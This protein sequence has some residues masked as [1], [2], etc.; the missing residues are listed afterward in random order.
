MVQDHT[1][2]EGHRGVEAR[3]AGEKFVAKRE[4]RMNGDPMG[5]FIEIG[6]SNQRH[7]PVTNDPIRAIQQPSHLGELGSRAFT[8]PRSPRCP[9]GCGHLATSNWFGLGSWLH[10]SVVGDS[11]TLEGHALVPVYSVCFGI[12]FGS[13]TENDSVNRVST[14]THIEGCTRI[15]DCLGRHFGPVEWIQLLSLVRMIGGK[16]FCS[17]PSPL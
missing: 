6:H 17:S 12:A 1:G 14:P 15:Q 9:C 8:Y 16:A 2:S 4:R 3:L 10:L 5:I 11:D 13:R 7:S